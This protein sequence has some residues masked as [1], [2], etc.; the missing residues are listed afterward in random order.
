MCYRVQE[1]VANERDNSDC[2]EANPNTRLGFYS[3]AMHNT[4]HVEPSTAHS[5]HL[6]SA[7][8][9]IYN[10]SSVE[11][12][13]AQPQLRT[14]THQRF[15]DV[16]TADFS[17]GMVWSMACGTCRRRHIKCDGS[18]P[19]CKQYGSLIQ[20]IVLSSPAGTNCTTAG[21]ICEGY[22]TLDSGTVEQNPPCNTIYIRNLPLDVSEEEIKALF[23]KKRG[24]KRLCFRT[25]QDGPLCFVEFDDISL[26]AKA[27]HDLQG[28]KLQNSVHGGIHLSF[29]KNPLGV[30]TEH[31]PARSETPS[32]KQFEPDFSLKLMQQSGAQPPQLQ[33]AQ[34]PAPENQNMS[35]FD[36]VYQPPPGSGFIHA[37]RK[38]DQSPGNLE[39]LY[40]ASPGEGFEFDAF[41]EEPYS[42][43]PSAAGQSPL[44]QSVENHPDRQS[45]KQSS[46]Q[47]SISLPVSTTIGPADT[48]RT[49]RKM[50]CDACRRRKSR[51]VMHEGAVLCVLCEFHKQECTFVQSPDTPKP[52]TA[53]QTEW[54][55]D[56]CLICDMQIDNGKVYCS[57]SCRFVD[58]L[59][60]KPNE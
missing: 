57:E 26:A 30:R 32:Q 20:K 41:V 33:N 10:D 38:G 16:Q 40:R 21:F 31:Q 51:C 24:Y 58:L 56:L 47:E 13:T 5:Q 1:Q 50:P 44:T 11:P 54:N 14:P 37:Y 12:S 28:Y 4:S 36:Q 48:V 8:Q 43:R 59:K 19:E 17:P 42:L 34:R 52:N 60:D 25:K 53:S 18:R 49:R 22:N 55:F 3:A 23:S 45:R 27:L 46:L 6:T 7:Y 9:P 2:L 29:S 15:R 35:F 39:E